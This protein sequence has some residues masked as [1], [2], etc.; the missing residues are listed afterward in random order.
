MQL[1]RGINHL[2]PLEKGCVL[3]IGNFDGVHTGHQ[4]VIEKLTEQSRLM[5]LPSVLMIFEPQPLEFFLG[6]NA[7]SR[8]TRL[9]EKIIQFKTLP[10]D[11]VIPVSFNQAMADCK[12]EDFI[13]HYLINKLNIKY[14]IIGDDFH[15]GK[16]RRGNFAMLQKKG[17]QL[18]FDVESTNSYFIDGDRVSSTLIRDTLG[19]GDMAKAKLLLGRD[20][21][22]SGRVAHGNKRGRT[23]GF[24]TAN[25][26]MFRKNTPI[27]GVFAVTMTGINHKEIQ[28]VANVGTRPT[29][30]GGEKVILE[31]HL[32]DFNEDIYGRYVDIK[33]KQKIRD[34]TRFD[35]L[36]AL[37]VQ[38]KKD[39][40]TAKQILTHLTR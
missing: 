5:N 25:V 37:Q 1:I 11:K 10:I 36:D 29:V 7:P 40:I 38:I 34:E 32:F 9:R 24:P 30:D 15:F 3:S 17:Q 2:K 23:I 14:L 6:K 28:G 27:T 12:A 16:A 33:F 18:G 13:N 8:L 4:K 22:V 21:S 35:S 19:I 20:Y 39:V 26:H 31:T